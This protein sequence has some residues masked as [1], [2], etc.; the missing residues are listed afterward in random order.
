MTV[1]IKQFNVLEDFPSKFSIEAKSTTVGELLRTIKTK[2]EGS[3][4]DEIFVDES[5]K[6][7]LAVL[8]NGISITLLNGANSVIKEGDQITILVMTCGG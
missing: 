6:P 7:H 5:I 3:V 8:L 4:Y 2:N 1:I